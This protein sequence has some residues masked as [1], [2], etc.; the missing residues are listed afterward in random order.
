MPYSGH[1]VTFTKDATNANIRAK[2]NQALAPGVGNISHPEVAILCDS[3][4]TVVII[5]ADS[6]PVTAGASNT[7]QVRYVYE[8]GPTK[9]GAAS[10]PCVYYL[11]GGNLE[12]VCW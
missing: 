8:E 10:D 5:F 6:L 7:A 1:K 3:D 9:K 12:K 2:I 11:A 4:G